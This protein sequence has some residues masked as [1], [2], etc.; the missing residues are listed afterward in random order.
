MTHNGGETWSSWYNQPTAQFYHVTTDN[1]FPYWV[2]GAQQ[3]S[4]PAATP[5]RSKYRSLNFRD[6]RP[7][8]AGDENGY[9]APDP[10]NPGVI[11]G[12]F[13]SRQDFSNEEVQE[14]PPT[15]AHPGAF[16]RTWTLPLVFSPLDPH[17]LYFGSQV[18]FRTADGGNSWQAISPDLTR[19]DPGVPANLDPATAADAPPG[20]RRGVIYTI[21]P[22]PVKAGEIWVG[23]DDGQIQLTQDEGKNWENV[24]PKELTSWSKDRKSTRLNSSH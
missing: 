4:G 22:S 10:L 15:I 5:S 19:E 6:W 14:M 12:G 11:F 17:V 2:Y 8:E 9:M 7:L 23:T 24:T 18:M 13:V 16:R 3:D 21:A 1:Q 20:K